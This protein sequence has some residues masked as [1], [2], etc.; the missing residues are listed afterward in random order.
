MEWFKKKVAPENANENK[1]VSEG[2]G[3]RG[4]GGLMRMKTPKTPDSVSSADKSSVASLE[5][6]KTKPVNPKRMLACHLSFQQWFKAE[7][8]YTLTKEQ[9]DSL[10]KE[11]PGYS[12]TLEHIVRNNLDVDEAFSALEC[13]VDPLFDPE[14][15]A[16]DFLENS[17][18]PQVWVDWRS[19]IEEQN[20]ARI[21]TSCIQREIAR[22]RCQKVLAAALIEAE[23][24]T[25]KPVDESAL[26]RAREVARRKVCLIMAME[27]SYEGIRKMRMPGMAIRV[28]SLERG[29]RVRRR[30]ERY[31]AWLKR[32]RIW[33]IEQARAKAGLL[34]MRGMGKDPTRET[35]E[36]DVERRIWGRLEYD[37][38]DGVDMSENFALLDYID[39]PPQGRDHGV[40]THK[41]KIPLQSAYDEKLALQDSNTWV[42]IPVSMKEVDVGKRTS[43]GPMFRTTSDFESSHL[44][45][46]ADQTKF[47]TSYSW[48]PA[49]LVRDAIVDIKETQAAAQ[50]E[51]QEV[52]VGGFEEEIGGN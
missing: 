43:I 23:M 35:F 48:I 36:P 29:N 44:V 7:K 25:V 16:R 4:F 40:R 21:I 17:H 15:R 9:F 30:M 28:Q 47:V 3:G 45:K 32:R 18:W 8:K 13:I 5:T 22:R 37:A 49:K 34:Y 31:K 6:F 46:S 12:A 20:R 26:A 11:V 39:K 33:M 27:L 41:V 52:E 19:Y 10:E 38:G 1:P 50:Q 42:G 24:M 51:N 2:N 14:V